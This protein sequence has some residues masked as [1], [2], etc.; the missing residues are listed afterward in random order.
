MLTRRIPHILC[1]AVALVADVQSQTIEEIID[2]DAGGAG[3]LDGPH[4]LAVGSNGNVYVTGSF[5]FDGPDFLNAVPQ[6]PLPP[7]YYML[8]INALPHC[9]P[10]LLV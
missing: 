1:V 5:D 8:S 7:D 10:A 4:Y 2:M 9:F 3:V 6:Y